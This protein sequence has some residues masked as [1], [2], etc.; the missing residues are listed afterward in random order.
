MPHAGHFF[1]IFKFV[2]S[3]DAVYINVGYCDAL[4]YIYEFSN[5]RIFS[6]L[7]TSQNNDGL[8]VIVY[9]DNILKHTSQK[10]D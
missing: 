5:Y 8:S 7:H 6:F 9:S 4:P 3:K 1:L 10:L 2:S